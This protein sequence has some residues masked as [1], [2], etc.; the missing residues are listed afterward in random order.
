MVFATLLEKWASSEFNDPKFNDLEL[1][2]ARKLCSELRG[3]RLASIQRELRE[4]PT[5]EKS[6]T[7]CT[8][9]FNAPT[10]QQL[11]SS[12][13]RDYA[14]PEAAQSAE[15]REARPIQFVRRRRRLFTPPKEIGNTL[16]R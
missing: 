9:E 16:A 14:T 3:R 15:S 13:A 11:S 5:G 12:V 1:A 4:E 7:S 8:R 2:T 10:T 6:R